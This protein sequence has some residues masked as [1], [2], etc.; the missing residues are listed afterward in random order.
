ME[1]LLELVGTVALVILGLVAVAALVAAIL[2]WRLRRWIGEK[3]LGLQPDEIHLVEAQVPIWPHPSPVSEF[4]QALE[5]GEWKVDRCYSVP[6]VPGTLVE[7]FLAKDGLAV[8]AI[9]DA[10]S[11]AKAWLDLFWI[12]SDDSSLTVT[13]SSQAGLIDAPP[14]RRRV[15]L[16]DA[17]ADELLDRF[18]EETAETSADR[19]RHDLDDLT[20]LFEA[21]WKREIAW[22]KRRG[23]KPAEV[24]AVAAHMRDE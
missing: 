13:N 2:W 23:I 3:A 24:D 21:E 4:R 10:P 6:E 14:W 15:V 16:R 7:L 9:A 18:E 12:E 11:P 5:D 19:R 20:E 8:A 1:N 22:R 17:S